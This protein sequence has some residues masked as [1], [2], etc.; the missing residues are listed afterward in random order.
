MKLCVQSGGVSSPVEKEVFRKITE[1]D[2]TR[3]LI[4]EWI[5]EDR[6]K[7]YPLQI[8]IEQIT[9]ALSALTK[10]E[11][12]IIECR[13]FNKMQ[14]MDTEM[15]FNEMFGLQRTDEGLGKKHDEALRKLHKILKPFY[16]RFSQR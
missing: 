6:I 9:M 2:L 12:F 8:E 10:H 16:E 4:S 15:S 13:Y 3:S 5:R 14:W 1:H 11:K 7:I